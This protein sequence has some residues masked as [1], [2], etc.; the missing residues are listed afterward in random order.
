MVTLLG[1]RE[2]VNRSDLGWFLDGISEFH[3]DGSMLV[4]FHCFEQDQVT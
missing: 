3:P 2:E 4:P 1:G